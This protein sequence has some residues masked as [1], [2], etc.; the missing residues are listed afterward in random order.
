M[1]DLSNKVCLVTGASKGVGRGTALQLASYGATCYIT[2]RELATLEDV[3]AEAEGRRYSGRIFPVKCD[4]TN[5]MN[6]RKV[7]EKIAIE[8]N[9]QLDLLVNNVFTAVEYAFKNYNMGFWK[10]DISNWDLVSNVELRN[11]HICSGLASHLMFARGRGLIVNVNTVGGKMYPLIPSHV[12]GKAE[13]DRVADRFT[14]NFQRHNVAFVS[15]L[16]SMVRTDFITKFIEKDD[17]D[18]QALNEIRASCRQML[19]CSESV[20]F[21]GKCIA[22]MLADEN[23]SKKAGQI[24]LTTDL[25][26]EYNFEDID[27]KSPLSE[28]SLKILTKIYG[29]SSLSSFIPSWLKLPNLIYNIVIRYNLC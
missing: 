6:T 4:H 21:Q 22:H 17:D 29:W 10:Q 12:V 11:N 8:Q 15:L 3:Q 16:P 9:G 18:D 25:A 14:L 5:E 13:K 1:P 20:E 26:E 23:I 24:L 28:R 27:G 19:D 7:F 2:G